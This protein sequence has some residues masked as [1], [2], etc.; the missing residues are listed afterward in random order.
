VS[1]A[2][3][4]IREFKGV[5]SP[6]GGEIWLI[7]ATQDI[8]W[9]VPQSFSGNLGIILMKDGV[10]IGNIALI[11][12][13]TTRSYSWP[14]G[15]YIGGTAAPGTGYTIRI[16]EIGTANYDVSDGPFEIKTFKGVLS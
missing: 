3:F 15:Q 1:D 5:T 13:P 8:T 2:S 12:D 14:V 6:N 7:G 9:N 16:K 4:R 10:K 11:T